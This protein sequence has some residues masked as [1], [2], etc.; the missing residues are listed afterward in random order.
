M[1]RTPS[2]FLQSM[3][4]DK[5]LTCMS[6]MSMK[7]NLSQFLQVYMLLQSRLYQPIVLLSNPPRF[8]IGMLKNNF[9]ELFRNTELGQASKHL[10]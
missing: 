9:D 4:P 6:L 1:R 7:H 10:D 3:N 2:M 8:P 5:H